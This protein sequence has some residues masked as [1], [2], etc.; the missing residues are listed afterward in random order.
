MANYRLQVSL[1][2]TSLLPRDY[3]VNT[4]YFQTDGDFFLGTGTSNLVADLAT[5]WQ[6]FKGWPAGWHSVMVKSYDMAAVAPGGPPREPLHT[7]IK[8]LGS[9]GVGAPREVALCLSYFAGRNLPRRRGRIYV[10]P[11]RASD[12]TERPD[13]TRQ[14]EL[15]TLAGQLSGLGGVNVQWVQHSPT[16]NAFRT[17]T[18]WFVDN[19]WDT[20]RRRGLKPDARITGTVSG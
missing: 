9:S 11:Y 17:V 10:G 6:T 12:M 20:Q 8:T 15:G 16:D 5:I 18:N 3:I 4:L 2:P 1:R 13:S 19:E 14:G 7:S